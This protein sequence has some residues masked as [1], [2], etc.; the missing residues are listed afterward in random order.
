[1]RVDGVHREFD[2]THAVVENVTKRVDGESIES[3]TTP[4]R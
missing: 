1:M 2:H 4:V 3:S